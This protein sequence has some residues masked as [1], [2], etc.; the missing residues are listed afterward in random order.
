MA[1][2]NNSEADP[3]QV[4]DAQT[5]WHNFTRGVTWSASAVAALLVLMA[6]FLV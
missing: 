3:K 1:Q 5:M 2:S 4:K 6:I